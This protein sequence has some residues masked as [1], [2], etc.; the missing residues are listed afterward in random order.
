[1]WITVF[2]FMVIKDFV[3]KCNSLAHLCVCATMLS[4]AQRNKKYQALYPHRLLVCRI[5]SLLPWACSWEL[6]ILRK[7]QNI[8]SL[9]F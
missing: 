5:R 8:A 4:E 3:T 9:I 7:L 2:V 6:L 1:M